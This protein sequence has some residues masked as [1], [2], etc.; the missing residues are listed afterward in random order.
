MGL[1][2]LGTTLT[3]RGYSTATAWLKQYKKKTVQ[4]SKGVCSINH[5]YYFSKMVGIASL[6]VFFSQWQCVLFVNFW[7]IPTGSFATITSDRPSAE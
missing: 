3:I 4:K 2:I 1:D 6:L 7:Q 5:I